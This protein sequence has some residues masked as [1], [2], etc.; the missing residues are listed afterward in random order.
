LLAKARWLTTAGFSP[1]WGAFTFP[2]AA[3]SSAMMSLAGQSMVFG[4]L[5]ALS[6]AG[7]LAIIPPIALRVLKLWASGQLALKTNA[8]R[9]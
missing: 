1:L 4:V 3:F 5:G 6:L 8:A 7:A 2:L 9:V